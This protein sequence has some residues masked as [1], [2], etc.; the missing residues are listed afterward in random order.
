M[1]KEIEIQIDKT[2][3]KVHIGS[4]IVTALSE[5]IND[6]KAVSRIAVITNPTV[7]KLYGEKV[8]E[9]LAKTAIPVHLLEVPDGEIYKNVS[10]CEKILNRLIE[11]DMD[12]GSLVVSLG[13]GVIGDLAGFVA[14]TYQRGIRFGQVPTTLLAAV[15]ASVGGKVAV[16]LARG[17]NMMG[18]FYQP[19]FVLSDVNFLHTLGERDYLCGIAEVI[20][21]GLIGDPRILEEMYSNR[22]LVKNRDEKMVEFMVER[23][24][25]YKAE[26]VSMDER[27]KGLR[28]V[29]NFGHT[30]AH[31]IES[32]EQYEGALHGEAVSC[33]LI[34][35][36]MLSERI[37]NFP[38]VETEKIIDFI[39]Y[40]GL[41]RWIEGIPVQGI[42]D[43][44]KYDKK[45]KNMDTLF[46]LLKSIGKA[47]FGISIPPELL[48]EVLV[49][50]EQNLKI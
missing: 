2:D 40:L 30:V 14:A 11:L 44:L 31:A 27:E 34:T 50:Q 32:Y 28:A 6:L 22:E 45:R 29:L 39:E 1:P 41:F 49:E 24:V 9:E 18:A 7:N 48:K 33:G 21:H 36:L 5:T 25:K 42:I 16:N 47:E 26:I 13:G 23:S 12:R 17:K 19:S 8:T 38:R 15:D 10:E 35:A 43:H 46:V 3:Y 20:K 37:N 4:E